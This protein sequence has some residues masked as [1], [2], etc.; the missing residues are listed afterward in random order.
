MFVEPYL[1]TIPV[2]IMEY[3]LALLAADG[4]PY[5]IAALAATCRLL[6]NMVYE[7]PDSHLW[8]EIFL[9][10]FDD[11]RPTRRIAY[12]RVYTM[13][14]NHI[15]RT[16]TDDVYTPTEEIPFD[17]GAEYRRRIWAERYIRSLPVDTERPPS[18]TF[19][20]AYTLPCNYDAS[21]FPSYSGHANLRALDAILSALDTAATLPPAPDLLSSRSLAS[22]SRLLSHDLDVGLDTSTST[23]T[24]SPTPAPAPSAD[25]EPNYAT[26]PSRNIAWVRALLSARLP[27]P[28]VARLTCAPHTAW[29][30]TLEAQAM[31]R[32]LCATG[33]FPR[34]QP[35]SMADVEALAAAGGRA[36]ERWRDE[37]DERVDVRNNARRRVY[38]MEYPRAIR[39]WGP[40]LPYCEESP[41]VVDEQDEGVEEMDSDDGEW[42]YG[43]QGS[44][45]GEEDGVVGPEGDVVERASAAFRIPSHLLTPDWAFLASVRIVIDANMRENGWEGLDGISELDAVRIGRWPAQ[46]KVQESGGECMVG[47]GEKARMPKRNM[48]RKPTANSVEGWD[49]AGVEGIWRQ[50]DL[51]STWDSSENVFIGAA[52]A[53]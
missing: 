48:G 3:I 15:N 11:P 44:G 24:V 46:R 18:L 33:W 45:D 50:V 25:L 13:P 32:L 35:A 36:V 22:I 28:W 21:D 4:E 34:P 8:R 29:E 37:L 2:E 52:Y 27:R 5:A 12:G 7:S 14:F 1:L 26:N 10:T 38:N 16:R 19:K 17:W 51:C 30:R 49:W 42:Y 9:T 40:F 6:Y 47:G 23:S 31:F 39:G 53:G 43:E 20:T 41:Y